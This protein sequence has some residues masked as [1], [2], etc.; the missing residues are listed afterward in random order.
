M[1]QGEDELR[2]WRAVCCESSLHGSGRGSWKRAEVGRV[3]LS[4]R[5]SDLFGNTLPSRLGE[6]TRRLPTSL[7]GSFHPLCSLWQDFMVTC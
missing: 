1:R 2:A 4:G 3:G 7:R 6:A 5:G